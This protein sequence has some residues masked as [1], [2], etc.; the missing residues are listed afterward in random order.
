MRKVP[1]GTTIAYGMPGLGAGYMYLL[2]SLYVMKFSTDVLLIAPA[3]MGV[4]FS[5]SRI[6]DA[7]SDPIAG[8]LSDRT[9]FKFGRRRTWMLISFIPISFGFLAVFSPPESM[10][11][12][13]LDLWMMIAILSFYSAITLLNVPHMALGA[14]LSED[15][16]ERTRLFGVRHIGFTLGSILALVSMSLLISE[17]NNPDGDVRQL[18]SS[19]A[20][21]AI[22]A[23][24]LMIFFAVSKLKEN[25]EF[26]NRVNKNPFK[27]FRD[28]WI[29]PHAKIL[30][31]VLFIENLGGA[32][33]GVLTLYVTQYIVEAPAWAPLIIFAYMLP[34]A[35]SVPLWIPLS[36][37]FGKI[38]LWVFS[39]AFTGISFGGIFI[40]PF[41]DSV[42]DRLI[43]MFIGAALGG[44]A[45]GCGGAIGP[46]VKGDV[47]DYDEYL[48]GERK[49]GSYFAALNFVFKSATGIMLLVT[50]FVLQFSGFIPNQPQTMEVKI[51]LISLYGLV[52]LVFYS[53]GA[54][55]LY[56]K[57]KFGEKEHAAIKQQIQERA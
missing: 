3:V 2:M 37:R 46:S 53:L 19:L 22:G 49:E 23:M 30:I 36:R 21:Y 40:I 1:L 52:P 6:W 34:S 56:K 29:N 48:T 33:I 26:Q 24:S 9:T 16:H 12:Q 32:V 25:P 27:A 20:F 38:R 35:L 8:Y 50:G 5:I 31:I 39:L 55:L 57:F 43:V 13:S 10:Q 54:Y 42:T 18:A 51:A 4:I 11:G 41:L 45:A 47:I 44:M 14:E 17:E 28:V 15:Y 7:V